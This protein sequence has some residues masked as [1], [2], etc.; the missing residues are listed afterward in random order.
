MDKGK[1]VKE[2]VLRSTLKHLEKQLSGTDMLRCH[3]SYLVNC[4][5]YRMLG[6]SRGYKLSTSEDP[7][8]IPVSRAH[9]RRMLE[10]MQ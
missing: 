9:S 10:R 8:T 7:R 1:L 4:S 2:K 3:R 6:D 5:R